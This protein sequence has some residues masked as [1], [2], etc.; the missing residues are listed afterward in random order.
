MRGKR[1]KLSGIKSNL[2]LK[3]S[4]MILVAIILS[5]TTAS[6]FGRNALI[7]NS[8][9]LLTNFA[10]Q[11]GEDISR[12]ID[13]EISKVEIVA[14][15]PIL[16]DDTKTQEEKLAYLAE[17]VKNQG[18]KKSA[19]IDLNGQCVTTLGEITDVSDKVYFQKNL[20]GKSYFTQPNVSKADGGLQISIT[21]PIRDNAGQITGIVFFS[22]DAEEFCQITNDIKFGETG[23]AYVVDSTGT[24]IMNNDIEKVKNKVNRIEDAKTDSSYEELAEITKKMIAGGTGTGEYA[25]GGETKFLGYAPVEST[26]WSVGVTTN[27]SDMMSGM[28]NLIRMLILLGIVVVIGM[29]V[30]TYI[31]ST[32]LANRLVKLKNEVE[33]ISTGNFEGKDIEDKGNDEITAI[34]QALENTKKSV[35]SMIKVIKEST[36]NL[37]YE[38]KDLVIIADKFLEGTANIN[39][40]LEQS[41]RGTE[42]QA[43]ELSAINIILNDFDSKL[44]ESNNNIESINDMAI[45]ISSKANG[46]CEDM[47]NLSK[48]MDKLNDSFASFAKEINEMKKAMETINDITKLI[49]DISDKTNLLALNAAIE[50]ARAGEAGK[51]FSVVADEIRVLAEQSKESTIN[52]NDVINEVILKAENIAE[53]SDKITLELVSG[54][55]NVENSISSF[56]VILNNVTEVTEMIK[57]VSENFEHIITQ[58][59]EIMEKVEESSAVSEEMVAT[60]EE[61]T[62]SSNAF[63]SSTSRIKDSTKKLSE[64]TSNMEDSV[65]KFRI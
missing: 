8:S 59:D 32:K 42:S 43:T 60:S 13:L 39:D 57:V 25:F 31:S 52:I 21:T 58:K 53:T 27:L 24:N 56:E 22:K 50:A 49:N 54:E 17:I 36:L 26:G 3:N 46:S 28:K 20:D 2:I 37:N 16:R 14:E 15:S 61:I 29:I 38:S 51:G 55:K 65:N 34:Y 6:I 35:G 47:D 19:L 41:T 5:I 9:E 30:F 45:D 64:L 33:E 23:T 7:S 62:A 12:V 63:V 44:N 11:V 10:K 40:A 4:V 1:I 18:Y 48:F